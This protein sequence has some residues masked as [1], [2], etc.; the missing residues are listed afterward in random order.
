MTGWLKGSGLSGNKFAGAAVPSNRTA[1]A[2]ILPD[3]DPPW[4]LKRRLGF[5]SVSSK[6][7]GTAGSLVR[8]V[9][10]N[11]VGSP[12]KGT[13][14]L[15]VVLPMNS[16]SAKLGGAGLGS[17]SEFVNGSFCRFTSTIRCKSVA[18]L[19]LIPAAGTVPLAFTVPFLNLISSRKFGWSELLGAL[20]ACCSRG[21]AQL[22]SELGCTHAVI[23]LAASGLAIVEMP[24][25]I[26]GYPVRFNH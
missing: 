23:V 22:Q 11:G 17:K 25:G 6:D 9:R 13:V 15:S 21:N 2:G 3:P 10:K 19:S 12:L 7:S 4:R 24:V 26:G 20:P 18:R 8:R 5:S 16:C 14:I 1:G